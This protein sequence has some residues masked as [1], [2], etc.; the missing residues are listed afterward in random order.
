MGPLT[1]LKKFNP[2]LVL[3]KGNAGTKKNGAEAEGKAI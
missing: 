1:H 2:D 3:S